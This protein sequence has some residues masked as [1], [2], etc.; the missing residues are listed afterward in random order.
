MKLS[1]RWLRWVFLVLYVLVVCTLLVLW[2]VGGNEVWGCV[3]CLGIFV[4]T[5]LLF[6]FGAGT[7]ELA[8]P[9]RRRR[10]LLPV[11]VAAAMV[12]LLTAAM[13]LALA[14]LSRQEEQPWMGALLWGLLGV[15]WVGWGALFYAHCRQVDRYRALRRMTL[16]ILGG[17]LVELIGSAVAHAIVSRRPGCLVGVCTTLGISAGVCVMLWAFGPGIVLLF[18]RDRHASARATRAEA[19]PGDRPDRLRHPDPAQNG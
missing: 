5:Q 2:L 11:L 18:L 6:V 7:V 15:S 17:S 3:V 12:A 9:I 10:L 1:I 14:E 19:A 8:R 4:G 13:A 16:W